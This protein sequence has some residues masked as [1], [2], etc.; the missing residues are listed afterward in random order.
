MGI[1]TSLNPVLSI[2]KGIFPKGIAQGAM[3]ILAE[4]GVKEKLTPQQQQDAE[5]ALR[6]WET[7][8]TNGDN[9]AIQAVNTTMQA[10]ANS[11]HV[12]QWIW[13]PIFGLTCAA[14]IIW[15]YILA[16][17]FHYQIIVIPSETWNVMLAV[18]GITAAT[19]GWEK[20]VTAQQSNTPD[21]TKK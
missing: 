10:E 1:L 3:D 17:A 14:V 5:A 16:P 6:K 2:V 7:D 15:N 8:M 18:L 12:L 9:I 4:A 11:E 21:T 20:I 13:R 19:R